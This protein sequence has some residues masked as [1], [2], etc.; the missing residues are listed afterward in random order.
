[1]PL[2]TL[3]LMIYNALVKPYF[4]YCS[5]LWDNCGAVIRINFRDCKIELQRDLLLIFDPIM[6]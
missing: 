1:M 6:C 3:K 2:E 4:D 5:P